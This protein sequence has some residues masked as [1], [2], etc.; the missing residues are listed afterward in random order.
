MSVY[1][2]RKNIVSFH[3]CNEVLQN[4]LLFFLL[5]CLFFCI[6]TCV[7]VLVALVTQTLI[8][9]YLHLVISFHSTPFLFHSFM[10]TQH[11]SINC[12]TMAIQCDAG[13]IK[14]LNTKKKEKKNKNKNKCKAY[15]RILISFSSQAQVVFF[16][17]SFLV[18]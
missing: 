12:T 4:D 7:K 17:F 14:K 3:F 13:N 10:L 1:R 15:S 18:F 11:N 8:Q 16:F 5:Y 6:C 9:L 2:H